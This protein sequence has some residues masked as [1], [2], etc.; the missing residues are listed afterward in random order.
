MAVSREAFG[1]AK[2]G[3]QIYRYYISNSKGFKAGVIN[4]GAILVNLFA[5]DKDGKL[6]DIVLGYDALEPYFEN[7][8]FFGAVI[9]PNANR[10][11][12]ASFVLDG[13]KY[14]LDI[15]DGAN[16]L[17]SHKELGYHKRIWDAQEGTDS[18]TFSL[19][20]EDGSMGFP[21][22][23]RISVTYTVTEDNE[24]RIHYQAESDRNTIINLTNHTY[25]NLAGH[26]S[27][28]ILDHKLQL[29]ASSY[30][31]AAEGSIPT[32]E[33]AKVEGTPFDFREG[34]R[35]GDEIDADNEQL[36][37]GLGYDHNWVIDGEIGR[38]REFATVSEEKSGRV[39]KAYTDLPGVQFYA[40]NCITETAGKEGA[41]YHKRCGLCLETQYYPDAANKPEFPSAVFGPDRKYDSLTVYKFL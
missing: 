31:P 27:E 35:I 22:N 6:Q 38:L 10:I 39:M 28:S 18:V 9:G 12:N 29:L 13:E 8:S 5:P 25:F 40:G 17:H 20:D 3:T 36:R 41:V 21:G 34:K 30:T 23:K 1:T 19:Q 16:N 7:G 24:L 2:C 11:G 32:G 33:I 14:V 37:I 15:N 4:Y 26:G